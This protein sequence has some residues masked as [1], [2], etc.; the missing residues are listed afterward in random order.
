MMMSTLLLGKRKSQNSSLRL[1]SRKKQENEA[2]II[3]NNF[4]I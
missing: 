4:P 3:T 2:L 1:N